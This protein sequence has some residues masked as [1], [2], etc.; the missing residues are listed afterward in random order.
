MGMPFDH[1]TAC[2]SATCVI[3][4]VVCAALGTAAAIAGDVQF[5]AVTGVAADDV[6]NMRDVPH[7][8]SKKLTG[9]PPDA[10][11]LKNLGCLTPEPSFDRWANM[12]PDERA[13]AKLQWCR[14]AYRGREGWVAAR[15][16]KPDR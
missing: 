3:G 5:W 12:T 11:G 6:L 8:D 9:I 10:R 7:G 16:L 13:N 4:T 1:R 14:V 2:R 15:F